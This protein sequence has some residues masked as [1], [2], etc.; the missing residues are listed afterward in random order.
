MKLQHMSLWDISDSNHKKK[1]L[2][3]QKVLG[4]LIMQNMVGPSPEVPKVLPSLALL[5]R[6]TPKSLLRGTLLAVR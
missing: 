2:W 1:Y 5:K 6:K 3:P 4:H